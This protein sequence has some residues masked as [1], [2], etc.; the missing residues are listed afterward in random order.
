MPKPNNR[1]VFKR[2]DG[3]WVNKRQD[4]ARATSLHETQRDAIE[5]ARAQ[6]KRDQGELTIN[7]RDGKIRS[8][9]SY[10]NDPVPP[11]DTE[12]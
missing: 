9:D 7:G 12:H 3:T 6:A 10:G 11:R 2:A 4:A 5:R 8:K 1:I